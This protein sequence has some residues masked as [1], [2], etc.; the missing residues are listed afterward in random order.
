MDPDLFR[1]M[2]EAAARFKSGESDFEEILTP[3]GPAHLVRDAS[4]P[5]GFRI[6]FVGEGARHSVP[7]QRYPPSST[8]P[9]GYP[10]PLPF[11]EDVPSIVSAAD[12]SVTWVDP[13][14][15]EH[16]LERLVREMVGEGW[17]V[18]A[19]GHAGEEA[20]FG[21]TRVLEKDGVRRDLVLDCRDRGA[22]LV[23][24]E[25]APPPPEL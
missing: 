10:A 6:D 1:R 11:L 4:D 24:R 5:R 21:A 16:L 18:A 3:A 2:Q 14:A 9:A 15:P 13:P 17:E 20:T 25:R 23:L 22:R 8:R 19:P 7:E 12:G